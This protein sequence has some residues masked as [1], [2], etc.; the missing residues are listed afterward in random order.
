MSISRCKIYRFCR[1]GIFEKTDHSM[2]L[3]GW[4]T[5]KRFTQIIKKIFFHDTMKIFKKRHYC[6][7]LRFKIR[8]PPKRRLR[9]LFQACTHEALPDFLTFRQPYSYQKLPLVVHWLL[10]LQRE[11][12]VIT[13]CVYK[14]ALDLR[15]YADFAMLDSALGLNIYIF[16]IWRHF[17]MSTWWWVFKNKQEIWIISLLL[18]GRT[19]QCKILPSDSGL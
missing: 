18:E 8:G 19:R 16:S 17:F 6:H 5:I 15:G 4:N 12:K 3:E 2:S 14:L 10:S 11:P 7:L 13:L 1:V 9:D